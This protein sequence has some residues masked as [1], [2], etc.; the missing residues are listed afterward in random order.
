MYAASPLWQQAVNALL[1]LGSIAV[2][3]MI[4]VNL[5]V[6]SL[7]VL[8]KLMTRRVMGQM[9]RGELDPNYL[10]QKQIKTESI[11][12]SLPNVISLSR[13]PI[14]GAVA[15]AAF[16]E[17]WTAALGL[18]L[19]GALTDVIDGEVARRLGYTS[20]LGA[21]V[22]DPISDL[23]LTAGAIFGLLISGR[24]P[25][26]LFVA[27]AV[28]Y[29]IGMLRANLGSGFWRSR[30]RTFLPFYY[31]GVIAA[32]IVTYAALALN[33][34]EFNTFAGLLAVVMV[35]LA[36]FKRHR[37]RAWLEPTCSSH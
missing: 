5:S 15:V 14:G 9:A 26:W 23:A 25:V 4:S 32:L 28:I 35:W 27:A 24:L 16:T 17:H 13:V 6:R 1:I 33:R 30:A 7:R 20:P 36:Y 22:V 8:D 2:A 21:K 31:L 37:F 19:L 12:K 29:T 18:L 3:V 34:T 11:M 10:E